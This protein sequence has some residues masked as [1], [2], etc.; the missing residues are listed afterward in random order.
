MN[1]LKLF[2]I[3]ISFDREYISYLLYIYN[4]KEVSIPIILMKIKLLTVFLCIL[5]TKQTCNIP[6]TCAD[7]KDESSCVGTSIGP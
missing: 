4:R 6:V 2:A 7:L 5:V 1:A 3:I